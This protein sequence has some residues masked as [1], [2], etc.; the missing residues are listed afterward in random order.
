MK[1]EKEEKKYGLLKAILAFALLAIILSW[2]L[3]YGQFSGTEF[4]SE[5]V[6]ARVGLNNLSEI[7]YYSFQF[8]LDKIV[9]LLIIAGFYGVL[10]KT[11][12]YDDLTTN[13]AKKLSNKKVAVVLFSVIIAVMASVFSQIFVVL[14]FVPF[15]IS[16]MNKMKL[17]KMTIFATTFGSMLV[18]ILGTTYGSEGL[19]L[20]TKSGYFTGDG[21]DPNKTVLIRAGILLIGLVLFNFFTLSHMN[22]KDKS[23]E[24]IDMFPVVESDEKKKS[25]LPLI[26]IGI[27]LFVIV[28]LGFVKW[29]TFNITIFDSFHK[30]ITEDIKIGQDFYIFKSILGTSFAAF[31]NWDIFT[32]SS[33]LFIFTIII[34]LCYRFKFN[35]FVSSFMDGCKKVIKP[36]MVLMGVYTIMT[37]IYMSPYLPT[38][39]NKILSLTDG[40][41]IATTSL[42]LMISNLFSANLDFIGYLGIL[43]HLAAEYPTHMNALY[44]M[45]SSLTGFVAIFAPTSLVLGVGLTSLDVKYK[46]WLKYIWKFLLGVLICLI[47]I[48][49]L[50]TVI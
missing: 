45:I 34:G 46:D 44:V 23:E 35:D 36:C 42:A 50:M 13:I 48:F 17:D 9:I 24:A 47:I 3:P 39:V 7:I 26:I 21:F 31:G 27:L 6:L 40:F 10:A 22:K 29:N 33:I 1:K 30:L 16:I 5:D 14:I 2:L 12:A 11:K 41:N 4:V 18:G 25:K 28:V 15:I 32:I 43:S 37:I 49:I 8:A 38:I 20:I 19:S